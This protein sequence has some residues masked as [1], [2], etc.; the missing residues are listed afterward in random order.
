MSGS[1]QMYSIPECSTDDETFEDDY[2]EPRSL[3][4]I[5]ETK[6]DFLSS[7]VNNKIDILIDNSDSKTDYMEIVESDQNKV[8]IEREIE[9]HSSSVISISKFGSTT[10]NETFG[11]DKTFLFANTTSFDINTQRVPKPYQKN[12]DCNTSS[13]GSYEKLLLKPLKTVSSTNSFASLQPNEQSLTDLPD[14]KNNGNFKKV[15]SQ[16]NLTINVDKFSERRRSAVDLTMPLPQCSRG[17]SGSTQWIH[18]LLQNIDQKCKSLLDLRRP[19][20]IAEERIRKSNEILEMDHSEEESSNVEPN[21]GAVGRRYSEN[22]IGKQK[23]FPFSSGIGHLRD[24]WKERND[25]RHEH[26]DVDHMRSDVCPLFNF[27]RKYEEDE[28]ILDALR[29]AMRKC[30]AV[31]PSLRPT[32]TSVFTQL[33]TIMK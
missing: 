4:K 16:H 5:N 15:S 29:Q 24:L 17:R 26:K 30:T 18:N 10:D 7:S 31:D 32:S 33:S 20:D 27:P 6:A 14:F 13:D 22:I 2:C 1:M 12:G 3:M 28:L 8:N 23:K 9:Q 25:K 11:N 21:S 19:S